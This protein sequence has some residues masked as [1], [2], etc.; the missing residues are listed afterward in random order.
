MASAISSSVARRQMS[1]EQAAGERGVRVHQHGRLQ[2]RRGELRKRSYDRADAEARAK[3]VH[4][5][6]HL[7]G[8]LVIPERRDPGRMAEDRVF[9]GGDVS[10]DVVA[11]VSIH[12]PR[13]LA[14]RLS[15]AL[16]ANLL[17]PGPRSKDC[18]GASSPLTPPAGR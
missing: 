2:H 5:L 7:A 1:L 8:D 13:S 15:R 6:A 4:L 9:A 18:P 14:A 10:P 3:R 11:D 12:Q 16:F 17:A